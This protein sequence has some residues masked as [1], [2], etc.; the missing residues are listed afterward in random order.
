[1]VWVS[2]TST[3]SPSN[4]KAVIVGY[5]RRLLHVM[6]DDDNGVELFEL[7]QQFFDPRGRDRIQGRGR[8]IH[9]QHLRLDREQARNADPL[10]L[11]RRKREGGSIQPILERIPQV[12]SG[13]APFSTRSSRSPFDRP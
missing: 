12:R 9:E 5:P 1:M 3:S 2:P 4:M 8:F 10:L 11:L 7:D 13:A 6:R